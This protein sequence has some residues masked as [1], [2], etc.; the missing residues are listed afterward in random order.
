MH[1]FLRRFAICICVSALGQPCLAQE[2]RA[3]LSQMTL[4]RVAPPEPDYQGP[5]ITIFIEPE[6]AAPATEPQL[7]VVAPADGPA[8]WFWSVV[9]A[10]LGV[11]DREAMALR[12]L[13]AAPEARQL[14]IAQT[15][16]LAEIAARHGRS[17]LTATLGTDVS[18]ALVLAVIAVESSGRADAVSGAGAQGLMQLIPATADRFD[19]TDPFDPVQNIAGGVAYLDWLLGAF[20]GDP[21]LALAGYNAGEGAVRSNGGVPDYAETRLYIPKVLA[22][23]QEVRVLCLSVPVQIRDGCVFRDL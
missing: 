3:P 2:P 22:T 17:I 18:P 5:R 6:A 21:L 11:V 10:Q 1:S 13:T 19:V 4:N 23:W 7:P 9:P 20:G 12:H 14:A 16:R 15:D 8:G